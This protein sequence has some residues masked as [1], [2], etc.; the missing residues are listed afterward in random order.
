M[1]M[2]QNGIELLLGNLKKGKKKRRANRLRRS[3]S[4][5]IPIHV[6][7][8]EGVVKIYFQVNWFDFEEMDLK[9]ELDRL[10]M[11]GVCSGY[12]FNR[13]LSGDIWVF[14]NPFYHDRRDASRAVSRVLDVL[15]NSLVR[16][17]DDELL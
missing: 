12:D 3:I 7:K 8:E 4:K 15:E 6:V 2:G 9:T 5:E 16:L 10:V 11:D 1:S 13:V 14:F 17:D